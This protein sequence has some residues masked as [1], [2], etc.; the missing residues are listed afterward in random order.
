MLYLDHRPLV[1][2]SLFEVV[3]FGNGTELRRGAT[4]LT[5][6]PQG[7]HIG[8]PNGRA[9]GIANP[10]FCSGEW[11]TGIFLALEN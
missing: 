5:G 2:Y 6:N 1:G 4:A 3:V 10:G 11:Q 7:I 9:Y 8:G